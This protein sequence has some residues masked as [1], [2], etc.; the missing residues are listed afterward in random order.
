MK[1]IFFWVN[2]IA[3]LPINIAFSH[4]KEDLALLQSLIL[5]KGVQWVEEQLGALAPS[6]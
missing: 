5:R 3:L 1:K 4:E 6:S 2:L